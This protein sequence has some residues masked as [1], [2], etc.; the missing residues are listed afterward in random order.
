M[1][2][3]MNIEIWNIRG[4]NDVGKVTAVNEMLC[5]IK[6]DII[7]L[8]E[9]KKRDFSPSYLKA[10]ASFHDFEWN[11]L[12]AFGTAGGILVGINVGMFEIFSWYKR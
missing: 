9:T 4:L 10:I 6:P 11:W 12:P 2:I 5:K 8:S 7:C 3:D 1:M